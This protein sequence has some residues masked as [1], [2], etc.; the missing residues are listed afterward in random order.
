M[1]KNFKD[2]VAVITGGASGIGRGLAYAFAERGCKIVLA[3][4]DKN[5]LDKVS[6]ELQEIGAEVMTQITDISDPE[7]VAH[8]VD[9]SY[10]RFGCV[11]IL[12]NNAGIAGGGPISLMS[13]EDWN[14][15]LSVN[16]FGIIY[17]LKYFLNRML[18]C[19]EPCHIINT[20]SLAG[21]IT[22]DNQPYAASKFAVVAISESLALQCY[23]TNVGVSVLCPGFVNTNILKNDE[24]LR[25]TRQGIWQPPPEMIELSK[26]MRE[27]A[28]RILALG[29]DPKKLAA[30]VIKAIENDILYILTH[31]E[32]IPQIKARFD[33]IYEDTLKLHGRIEGTSEIKTKIYRNE[34]HAFSLNLP[35]NLIELN[36]NPMMHP[37]YK[38]IFYGTT[39]N[40]VFELLIFV[41]SISSKRQLEGTA[42]KIARTFKTRAKDINILSN[43]PITLEDGTPAYE[44]VIEFK[45]AGMMKVKSIHLSVFKDE[46]WIRVSILT[47]AN[48]YN[49][50]FKNILHSLNFK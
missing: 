49:E 15:V 12:C 35:E 28:E 45:A 20:S 36:P 44:C 38:P 47:G 10:E 7:Q 42:K 11:N 23:N 24:I 2:K 1:I 40:L 32:Y 50:D 8:L 31:A 17:S 21:L 43:E 37:I 27:N 33:H 25:Q 22:S 39:K 9:A 4:I 16:L 41:S 46:K 18:K 6:S 30:M 14:W 13:L 3:D 48:Y 26:P 29:M 19:K 5:G 34:S